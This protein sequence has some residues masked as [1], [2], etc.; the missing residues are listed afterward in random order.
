MDPLASQC[1]TA[2]IW[3]GMP[4]GGGI[5]ALLAGRAPQHQGHSKHR[6][7]RACRVYS[8]RHRHNKGGLWR[9]DDAEPCPACNSRA[10]WNLESY[11][12]R[13]DLGEGRAPGTG[14]STAMALRRNL[15]GFPM[16]WWSCKTTLGRQNP[17]PRLG[18][19]RRGAESSHMAAGLQH[20]QRPSLWACRLPLQAILLPHI[21]IL[22]SKSI[23][24]DSSPLKP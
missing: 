17:D 2:W 3:P 13:I 15:D 8:S 9:G 21:W 14:I 4:S 6:H 19:P 7:L 10:V 18:Q 11:P 20:I 12:G 16:A 5:Q 23:W 22:P 1:E 24:T